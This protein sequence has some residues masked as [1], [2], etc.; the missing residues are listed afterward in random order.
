M[1]SR[2]RKTATVLLGESMKRLSYCNC[3]MCIIGSLVEGPW[4]ELFWLS[5]SLL[6]QRNKVHG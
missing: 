2:G 6:R 5:C 3:M 4:E 1:Y